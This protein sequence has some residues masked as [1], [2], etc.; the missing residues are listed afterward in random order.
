MSISFFYLLKKS[1]MKL[2][3]YLNFVFIFSSWNSSPSQTSE[4]ECG[5]DEK[6]VDK[7]HQDKHQEEKEEL[8]SFKDERR[9]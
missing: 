6:E 5:S 4:A 7:N 3:K 9:W 1:N 8:K 2:I